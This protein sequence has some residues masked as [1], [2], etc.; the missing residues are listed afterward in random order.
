VTIIGQVRCAVIARRVE[1]TAATA[2]ALPVDFL[3]FAATSNYFSCSKEAISM[4]AA[5]EDQPK[6][7]MHARMGGAALARPESERAWLAAIVEFSSDAILSKNLDGTITS[8]NAAA[9]RMYGYSAAEAIGRSIELIV[10]EDRRDELK[11]MDE[12]LARGEHV[13]PLETVRLTRDGRRIDVALT[14]SPIIDDAGAVVGASGIGRDVSERRRA[15]EALRRSQAQLKDF[16]KNSTL[17]LQWVG[18]DGIVIWANQAQLDLLGYAREEYIGRHVAEFHVDQAAIGEM[19]DRLHENEQLNNYE[20]RLRCRDGSIRHVLI[21]SNVYFENGQFVHTRCFASDITE[22]KQAELVI[23]GQKRALELIVEGAPL[24]AVLETL[25]RTVEERSLHDALASILLLDEAG[26]RLRHG[27]APS[28]PESY[29]RAI[30]G[31]TI[32]AAAGSCGTAARRRRAVIVTDIA[33]SPLWDGYRELALQHGLRACWSAPILAKDERV[34]GTYAIYHRQPRAPSAADLQVIEV[35]SRTAAIAIEAKRAERQARLLIEELNH[36]VKNTLAIAQSLATQTMRRRS[37]PKYF[38]AAFSGRLAA[39]ASSHTL[40]AHARWS[41]AG[42]HAL[43][44]E[45]LGP[46]RLPERASVTIRGDDVSLD[47]SAALTLGLTLHEL[48]TNAAKHGALASPAGAIEIRTRIDTAAEGRRL[49]LSWSE[50]GG[51]PIAAPPRRGFGLTLIEG[52]LAYQLKGN[53]V[54]DF[55]R[56]GLQCTLEFPLA[57]RALSLVASEWLDDVRA[58]DQVG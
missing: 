7:A 43:I 24:R 45:Q 32:G 58:A 12:R 39:L 56:E 11:G 25:V 4:M 52:G 19:L 55:R 33:Q 9:E 30:E 42:L 20:A 16:V 50:R 26:L 27:A 35:L 31:L 5:Q 23:A 28:L 15:D 14:M 37:S 17:G 51:P 46:Y 34:L 57:D 29:K 48:A 36:R 2:A 54:L 40:L 1:E 41:G 47:P 49:A 8:W 6:V 22:R 53:A 10:P 38:A 3:D 18:P 13:P 21:S 44:E